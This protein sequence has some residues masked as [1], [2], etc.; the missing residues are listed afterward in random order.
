MLS[1]MESKLEVW[2]S[3]LLFQFFGM[4][5]AYKRELDIYLCR[6]N[7]LSKFIWVKDFGLTLVSYKLS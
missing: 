4:V 3:C 2:E 7:E 5:F 6:A 1:E